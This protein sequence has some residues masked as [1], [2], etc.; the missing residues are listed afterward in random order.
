MYIIHIL[1]KYGGDILCEPFS[2]AWQLNQKRILVALRIK[3]LAMFSD[4]PLE[5]ENIHRIKEFYKAKMEQVACFT[6]LGYIGRHR[7]YLFL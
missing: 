3:E 6:I 1:I 4:I 2:V 7:N 5:K